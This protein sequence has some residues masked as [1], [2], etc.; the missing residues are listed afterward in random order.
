M[1][2]C[3]PINDQAII[4]SCPARSEQLLF[5]GIAGQDTGMGLRTWDTI[6]K[7][8]GMNIIDVLA[9]SFAT[10]KN[11]VDPSLLNKNYFIFDNGIPKFIKEDVLWAK[12]PG[13]GF[14][15]LEDGFNA[16]DDPTREFIVFITMDSLSTPASPDVTEWNITADNTVI[17]TLGSGTPYQV[18]T[19]VVIPNGHT[20]SWDSTFEFTD[21]NPPQPGLNGVS[22]VQEYTFRYY[23]SLNKNVC[24]NQSLNI[25][26]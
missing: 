17:T 19:V 13:G 24:V 11:Y 8:L 12:L 14:T 25:A 2:D 6:V 26:M 21:N 16:G 7:C 18:R 9:S 4:T 20:Y 23:P 5:F 10:S 3:K 15:I 22:T 1:S